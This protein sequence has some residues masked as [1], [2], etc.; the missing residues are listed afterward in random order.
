[1]RENAHL[2]D[3]EIEVLK[4]KLLGEGNVEIATT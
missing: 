1:M 3:K 2:K 4:N